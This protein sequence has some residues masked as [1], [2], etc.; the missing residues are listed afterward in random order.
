MSITLTPQVTDQ[1]QRLIET[2]RYPDADAVPLDALRL[3]EGHREQAD[4]LRAKLQ[5]GLD[6]LDRDESVPC[7]DAL[8]EELDRELEVRR[9]TGESPH[10]DV[11]P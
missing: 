8:F 9:L 11:C 2:G 5:I 1:I 7:S 4:N 6:Q 3:L 10:P